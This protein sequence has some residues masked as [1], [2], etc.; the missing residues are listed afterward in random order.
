MASVDKQPNGRW[1]ARYRDPAGRSRSR[2]FRR[3]VDA[4]QFLA[5]TITDMRRGDWIDPKLRRMRFDEWADAFEDGLVRLAPTTARRYRQILDLQVRPAFNGWSIAAIDRQDVSSFIVELLSRGLS[6]KTTRDCVSVLSLVMQ[7]AQRARVIRDNP[8][9]GHHI[10]V[11]RQRGQVLPLDQLLRLVE[12]TRAD[13][14]L[15]VLVLVYTGMR[16]SELCG[17]RV[18]R[19]DLFKGTVH[20]CETLTPVGS[21]LVAGTTKTDQERILPL[22]DFVRDQLAEHLAGRAAQVGRALSPEDY[23]FVSVKGTPLNR[24]F[25]RKHVLVPALRATGLPASFRTY[26]LRHAHASQL[27]DMGVSP[28]AIK[29][30]LG[31]ADVLTTFR[32]YGHLFKGVQERLTVQ[33]EETHREALERIGQSDGQIVELHSDRLPSGSTGDP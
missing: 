14:R 4:E 28:L 21:G 13:Y 1:R 12:N 9:A 27:I 10:K 15:A 17:L 20:V 5:A 16:P 19:L 18:R 29:E 24:D 2:T 33:L 8:A 31:H 23:V 7:G 30:R 6:P 22:P 25:L 3:K 32:K 26:D 11:S